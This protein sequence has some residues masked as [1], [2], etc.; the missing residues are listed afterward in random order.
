[1][2]TGPTQILHHAAGA[3]EKSD[4]SFSL[5]HKRFGHVNY[6]RIQSMAAEGLIPLSYMSVTQGV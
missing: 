3:K 6:Q 4:Q 5:W 2:D 1:M